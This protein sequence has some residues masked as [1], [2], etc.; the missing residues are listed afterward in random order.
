MSVMSG[1]LPGD[2]DCQLLTVSGIR[3]LVTAATAESNDDDD[4][5][6]HHHH[7]VVPRSNG[8]KRPTVGCCTT[9]TSTIVNYCH[10]WRMTRNEDNDDKD[11]EV[12]SYQ[13][14]Q[15]HSSTDVVVGCRRPSSWLWSQFQEWATINY[16]NQNNYCNNWSLFFFTVLNE[17]DVHLQLSPSSV[18]FTTA[19]TA[20]TAT[21]VQ[22]LTTLTIEG[23]QADGNG[24]NANAITC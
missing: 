1:Q 24:K 16:T 6:N 11:K 12:I 4:S 15:Q 5:D 21:N 9:E 3:Y 22:K 14:A 20:T 18:D 2:S 23:L 7:D 13:Q 8:T 10:W 17:E 19:T